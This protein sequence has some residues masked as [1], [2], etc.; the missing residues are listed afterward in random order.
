MRARKASRVIGKKCPWRKSKV[1]RWG[2]VGCGQIAIDK[3]IPALLAASG[4]RLVAVADILPARRSLALDLAAAA[5]LTGLRA[6]Q[7]ATGLF[8]DPDVDAVYIA[9]PTGLHAGAVIAA[10]QAGKAILCEKPLG[11]SVEEVAGMI[12]AARRHGV[13]LMTGYMSRFSDP[14]RKAVELVQGGAIGKVTHVEAHFSYYCL[15]PYPPGAP[16]GWRWTDPLG[17]GPLLDIGIYL[18]F[19]LREILG[20]RIAQLWPVNCDT[21]APAGAA[22]RDSTLACFRTEQG[23]PGTFVTTFSHNAS[24][25]RFYG[26]MGMLVLDQAFRQTPGACLTCQGKDI[27]LVLDTLSDAR[28]PHF[29]NY[30]RE[31]EHF[32]AALL[33]GV[34]WSPSPE[35]ALADALLL[36]A[37]RRDAVGHP[38]GTVG[39]ALARSSSS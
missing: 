28:I 34:A 22:V 26:S 20:E 6:H 30:R 15:D 16:G 19:G 24:V 31:F 4:A 38:V 32:S 27:D 1:I 36:D 35:D 5:G 7:D 10:A 14:F 8:A 21:I 12:R 13:P 33:T 29:D 17:G 3:T 39:A 18:A 23:T 2:V 11:R 25:I 37:L 9:L